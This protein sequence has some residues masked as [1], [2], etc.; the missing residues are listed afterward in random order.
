MPDSDAAYA[1]R[2]YCFT[3]SSFIYFIRIRESTADPYMTSTSTRAFG[4][5][6]GRGSDL[7]TCKVFAVNNLSRVGRCVYYA[8]ETEKECFFSKRILHVIL[9]AERRGHGRSRLRKF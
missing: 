1:N 6:N 7:P 5:S 9:G 3:M 2:R 4:R 8:S